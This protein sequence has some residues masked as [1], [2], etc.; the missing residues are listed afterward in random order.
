MI[1]SISKEGIRINQ[2]V[3]INELLKSANMDDCRP[4]ATPMTTLSI[5]LKEDMH[6]KLTPLEAPK[7]RSLVG[8]ILWL[9]L[10]TRPD[11]SYAIS[12]LGSQVSKPSENDQSIIRRVLKYLKSTM[13]KGLF[14]SY[15]NTT[16]VKLIGYS[17][18]SYGTNNSRLSH[19]GY[20]FTWNGTPIL[21]CS[22]RQKSASLSTFEAE[23]FG[24]AEAYKEAL[25]LRILLENFKIK[26][27]SILIYEDNKIVISIA[28]GTDDHSTTKHIGFRKQFIQEITDTGSCFPFYIKSEF[29]TADMPTKPLAK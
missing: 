25:W 18:A 1:F 3:Y 24:M 7:F 22:K 29:N 19:Y 15:Q 13:D 10:C 28:I 21:W 14:F 23:L 16:D 26:F 27:N 5:P 2:T 17:D 6:K 4:T 11:I 8:G 9:S 20:I 12:K